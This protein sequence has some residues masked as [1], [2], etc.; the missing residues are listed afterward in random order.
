M[1][2]YDIRLFTLYSCIRFSPSFPVCPSKS[3]KLCYTVSSQ[4]HQTSYSLQSIY[5]YLPAL[6]WLR[7][8]VVYHAHL[9]KFKKYFICYVMLKYLHQ[10]VT[11]YVVK[12]AS[13][14]RFHNIICFTILDHFYAEI[15][16]Y[17]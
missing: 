9:S 3:S 14:I 4:S 10:P 12:E 15:N 17:T 1:P 2:Y 8:P 7:F 16:Y 11:V 13:E 5:K 6:H